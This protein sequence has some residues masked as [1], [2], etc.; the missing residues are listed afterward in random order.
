MLQI[1]NTENSLKSVAKMVVT[2]DETKIPFCSLTAHVLPAHSKPY[3][4]QPT[5]TELTTTRPILYN[6]A[7]VDIFEQI[8]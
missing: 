3:S 1:R 5:P 2:D 4:T 7:K 8:I 6:L